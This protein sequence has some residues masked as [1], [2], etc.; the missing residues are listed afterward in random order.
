M[1][2]FLALLAAAS[3]A[4]RADLAALRDLTLFCALA[5]VTEAIRASAIKILFIRNYS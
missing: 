3:A 4:S 2:A 1:V 5:K